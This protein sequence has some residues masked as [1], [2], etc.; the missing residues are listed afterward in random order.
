MYFKRLNCSLKPVM[1]IL[2]GKKK[3]P[4]DTVHF[5]FLDKSMILNPRLGLLP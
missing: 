5:V 3:D 2:V 4:Q 1:L